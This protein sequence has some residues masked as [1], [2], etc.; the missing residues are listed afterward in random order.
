MASELKYVDN[1]NCSNFKSTNNYCCG[2][3]QVVKCYNEGLVNCNMKKFERLVFNILKHKAFIYNVIRA[4]KMARSYYNNRKN[5]C[6]T[7][8]MSEVTCGSGKLALYL[9]YPDCIKPE[10]FSTSDYSKRTYLMRIVPLLPSIWGCSAKHFPKLSSWENYYKENGTSYNKVLPFCSD[11]TVP[12]TDN[13]KILK[14]FMDNADFFTDL[15]SSFNFS[16]S[17][18]N[19]RK[20]YCKV[21]HV[22]KMLDPDC[23][24]YK[25]RLNGEELRMLQCLY[26]R[27]TPYFKNRNGSKIQYHN[28]SLATDC[29]CTSNSI[30]N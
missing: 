9:N 5:F 25:V 20:E 15:L 29:P 26:L 30:C 2:T 19:E 27:N 23:K 8:N 28:S 1:I 3:P 21:Y 24:G 11:P 18:F 14:D 7:F 6:I 4:R 16:V 22:P 10:V 17:N 13:E 12:L